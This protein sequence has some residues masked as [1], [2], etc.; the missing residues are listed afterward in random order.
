MRRRTS[1]LIFLLMCTLSIGSLQSTAHASVISTQQ[2]LSAVDRQR[3]LAQVD[4]VLARGEVQ[5]KLEQL[6][7]DPAETSARVAALTDAELAQLAQDLESLP[8]GGL[9]E[10]IGIVFVVLLILEL[11]GVTNIFSRM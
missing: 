7:V 4:A 11:V 2:Y 10:V 1:S 5:R 3:V 6:G 8:A 9:L